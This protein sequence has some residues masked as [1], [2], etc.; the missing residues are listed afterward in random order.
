LHDFVLSREEIDEG[1]D[2]LHAGGD[3]PPFVCDVTT[4]VSLL[5]EFYTVDVLGRQMKI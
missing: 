1:G 4:G 2:R 5:R 3:R